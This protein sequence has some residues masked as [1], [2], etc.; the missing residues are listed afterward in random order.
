[1]TNASIPIGASHNR[2][3]RAPVP[4]D[5]EAR[6]ISAVAVMASSAAR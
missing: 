1:M 4:S 5:G 2:Y 3:S 6:T